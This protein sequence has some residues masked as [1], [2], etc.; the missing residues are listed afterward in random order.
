MR[1]YF[2]PERSSADLF[3]IIS[4]KV[5][6]LANNKKKFDEAV[7]TDAINVGGNKVE[8]PSEWKV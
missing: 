7:M 1:L 3:N 2:P 5:V 6:Y 8:I 4:R